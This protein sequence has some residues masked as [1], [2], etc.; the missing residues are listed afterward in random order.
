[1]EIIGY[2]ILLLTVIF[3][4]MSAIKLFQNYMETKRIPTFYFFLTYIFFIIGGILLTVEKMCFSTFG[5]PDLG[6]LM[7]MIAIGCNGIAFV[8]GIRFIILSTYPER[9]KITTL[10]TAILSII[11]VGVIYYAIITGPPITNIENFELVYIPI[12][13]IIIYATLIPLLLIMCLIFYKYSFE[14]RNIDK[15]N[16]NRTLWLATGILIFL[17]G[18]LAEYGP[19]FPTILSVPFR[20]FLLT[21]TFIMYIA[22]FMP[23][24]FKERIGWKD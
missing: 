14:L 24:W 15:A 4:I 3:G 19:I 20:I 22:F 1:M 13:N 9:S 10:F 5:L 16:S 12:I 7:A 21:G 11:F 8:C 23:Q 17:L 2:G 18:L 6:A